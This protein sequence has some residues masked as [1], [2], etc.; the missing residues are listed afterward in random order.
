MYIMWYLRIGYVLYKLY[1]CI[2][3]LQLR[4]AIANTVPAFSEFFCVQ[5]MKI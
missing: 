5:N 3:P 4:Y 1:I 2:Q